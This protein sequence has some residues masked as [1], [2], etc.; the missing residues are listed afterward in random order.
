[1]DLSEIKKLFKYIKEIIDRLKLTMETIAIHLKC[2][3]CYIIQNKL[4]QLPC[5]HSMCSN[6]F[7]VENKCLECEKDFDREDKVCKENF[8]LNQVINRYKYAQQ[9]IES[10]ISLMINTLNEYLSKK[11]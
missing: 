1:V 4:I 8:F 6:C 11:E 3:N 7:N 10:D 5:G 2:K 9:Q